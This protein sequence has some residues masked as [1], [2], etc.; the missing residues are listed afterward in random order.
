MR[1]EESGHCDRITFEDEVYITGKRETERAVTQHSADNE[2]SPFIRC[3]SGNSSQSLEREF[4]TACSIA[5]LNFVSDSSCHS[6]THP[7]T[8]S[9]QKRLDNLA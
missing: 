3:A 4:H 1:V 5:A 2:Q 9:R 8:P 6:P 7:L